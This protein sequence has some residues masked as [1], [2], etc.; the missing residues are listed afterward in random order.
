MPQLNLR[1]HKIEYWM[2]FFLLAAGGLSACATSWKPAQGVLQNAVWRI[3]VPEGWMRLTSPA[4]IM[5][6]KDGPYLE[7]ILVQ[8]R[9]LSAGFSYS[10]Q[11]LKQDMLP[12]EMAQVV[13]DSLLA[14]PHIRDFQLLVN[15]PAILG[16]HAGFRLVYTFQDDQGV[17]MKTVYY[18]TALAHSFMNVRYTAAQRHYFDAGLKTFEQVIASLR[19]FPDSSS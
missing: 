18:G 19:L 5:L 8:D 12:H 4:Y 14:D 1:K 15:T 13:I 6:S 16:G 9:P 17:D 11:Y 7:Y 2:L 3:E 10:R